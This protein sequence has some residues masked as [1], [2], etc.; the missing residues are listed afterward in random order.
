[1]SHNLVTERNKHCIISHDFLG[2]KFEPGLPEK[3]FCIMWYCTLSG[4]QV[5]RA[6]YVLSNI[7]RDLAGIVE[8]LD[9]VG[10]VKENAYLWLL[11]HSSLRESDFL[12]G[13]LELHALYWYTM[14]NV[15]QIP[16]E[17]N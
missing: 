7:S 10:T 14:I 9:T 2:H 5:W 15:S 4:G 12:C 3:F 16:G 8:R 6:Q 17:K 13:S 1:M 11:L